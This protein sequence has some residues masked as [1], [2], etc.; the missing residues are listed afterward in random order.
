MSANAVQE[1]LDS[2]WRLKGIKYPPKSKNLFKIVTQNRNGPCSLIA[3]VNILILRRSITILPAERTYVSYEYLASLVADYLVNSHHSLSE[4]DLN[5]ALAVLPLIQEGMDLNP[6]FTG[7]SSFSDSSGKGELKLFQLCGV[8]LVHG[9]LADPFSSEY[10]VISKAGDYDTALNLIVAGEESPQ[11]TDHNTDNDTHYRDAVVIRQ[12]LESNSTQLTYYGLFSLLDIDS[13]LY[14]F[15]R[16]SHLSVLLRYTGPDSESSLWTLV[17]DSNFSREPEVVWESLGDVDGSSSR[18]V[19]GD[20]ILSSTA[21]G[22]FAG[23]TTEKVLQGTEAVGNANYD[24]D[25]ALAIQL[26]AEENE[27][28][29]DSGRLNPE[30]GPSSTGSATP[31]PVHNI[32]SNTPRALVTPNPGPMAHGHQP[33][34][35]QIPRN[36]TLRPAPPSLG[37]V[38]RRKDGPRVRDSGCIIM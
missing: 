26:Q 27:L 16:N 7:I 30:S 36:N 20:L 2:V 9:W 1:S 34:R 22:D 29:P 28:I 25:L 18:F 5:A 32:Q 4:V 3:L 17:T 31:V 15:I 38:P 8:T 19:N 14:A 6:R 23:T 37:A 24:I 13:G 10:S 35:Q 11:N 12:F 21:G 33:A